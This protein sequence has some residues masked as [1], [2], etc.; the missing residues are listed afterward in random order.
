[1]QTANDG[2]E[3]ER[4]TEG[5]EKSILL[6]IP[7]KVYP[8]KSRTSA[9]REIVNKTKSLTFVVYDGEALEKLEQQLLDIVQSFGK[10]A[11]TDSGLI[12]EPVKTVT[13]NK[14]KDKR[15]LR[16]SKKSNL[17]G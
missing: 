6:E 10:S 5:A 4:S 7:K 11:P 14:Y 15:P 12:L 13:K 16:K 17:T 1:M 3:A 2:L 9:C 8:K